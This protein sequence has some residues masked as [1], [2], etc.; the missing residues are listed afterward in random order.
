GK[1]SAHRLPVWSY[2]AGRTASHT[3]LTAPEESLRSLVTFLACEALTHLTHNQLEILGI[4]SVL[5]L[6]Y[7]SFDESKIHTEQAFLKVCND[8]LTMRLSPFLDAQIR[9]IDLLHLES[10]SCAR[11]S[12]LGEY[13]LESK[14]EFWK[15]RDFGFTKDALFQ[16]PIGEKIKIWWEELGLKQVKLTTTGQLVGLNVV[17]T[18]GK[19]S[20]NFEKWGE[21]SH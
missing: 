12:D 13:P 1:G 18:M 14:L 11:A 6:I 20:I 2:W 4:Q 10:L 9:R 16:L 21:E 7:P 15:C 3:R 5:T 8:W 19:T 17:E